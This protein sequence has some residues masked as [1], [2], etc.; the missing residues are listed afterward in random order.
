MLQ[1]AVRILVGVPLL[2][3]KI[4]P[5]EPSSFSLTSPCSRYWTRNPA[6]G[7]LYGGL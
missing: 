2:C 1:R 7:S 5:E 6:R 3:G 4:T